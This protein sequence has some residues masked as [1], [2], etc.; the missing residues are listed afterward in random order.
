MSISCDVILHWGSTPEVLR[1][2]G[3]ALWRWCSGA[4]GDTGICQYLDNQAGDSGAIDDFGTPMT[5]TGS[6]FIGNRARGVASSLGDGEGGAIL[7]SAPTVTLTR[8]KPSGFST[9]SSRW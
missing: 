9:T 4:A 7:S 6:V 2:L 3:A 5:V 1:A 8:R